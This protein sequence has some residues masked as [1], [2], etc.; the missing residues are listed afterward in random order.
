MSC[1]SGRR[2]P[3]PA[4]AARPAAVRAQP[5]QPHAPPGSGGRVLASAEL[6]AERMAIC[7]A[8]EH[9]RDKPV[10]HCAKCGCV[11][12]LKTKLKIGKCPIGKW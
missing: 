9:K 7:Q 10:M 11:L 6:A 3:P 4:P 12:A 8:C 1:C 2:P 5:V